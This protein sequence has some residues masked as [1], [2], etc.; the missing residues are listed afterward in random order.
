MTNSKYK[1]IS[2]QLFTAV[3][4]ARDYRQVSVNT[5]KKG[6][7]R[8]NFIYRPDNKDSLRTVC[9]IFLTI[10]VTNCP[11]FIPVNFLGSSKDQMPAAAR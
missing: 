2:I 10:R 3:S 11:L 1:K 8:L 4:K 7:D 5:G 6:T 9:P